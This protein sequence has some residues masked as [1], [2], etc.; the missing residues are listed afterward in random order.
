[1]GKEKPLSELNQCEQLAEIAAS[2]RTL[3]LLGGVKEHLIP[4][5]QS[6]IDLIVHLLQ[7]IYPTLDVFGPLE[8]ADP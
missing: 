3:A 1:M 7:E 6:N 2:L 4:L 8:K 5:T